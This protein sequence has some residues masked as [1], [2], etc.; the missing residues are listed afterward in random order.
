MRLAEEGIRKGRNLRR[1][2]VR[3][4]GISVC[5]RPLMVMRIPVLR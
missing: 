3:K 2:T 5:R 1:S 4:T